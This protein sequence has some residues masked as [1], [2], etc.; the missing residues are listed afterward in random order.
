MFVLLRDRK[1]PCAGA[2]AAHLP[3]GGCGGRHPRA[4]RVQGEKT[5]LQFLIAVPV[6][7][8][9]R[10][11]RSGGRVCL[12]NQNFDL[13]LGLWE[14]FAQNL[15]HGATETRQRLMGHKEPWTEVTGCPSVSWCVAGAGLRTHGPGDRQTRGHTESRVGS[16]C[17]ARPGQELLYLLQR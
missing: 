6:H 7:L 3:G 12:N 13:N 10:N 4:L 1:W 2:D 15:G 5:L 16:P 17:P 11:S 14:R 8:K 9:A